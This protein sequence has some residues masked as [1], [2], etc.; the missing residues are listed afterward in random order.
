MIEYWIVFKKSQNWKKELNWDDFSESGR[1][2]YIFKY[3]LV[4]QR[5]ALSLDVHQ[6]KL[7]ELCM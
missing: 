7:G 4:I 3:F 6:N 2:K 1:I 5:W